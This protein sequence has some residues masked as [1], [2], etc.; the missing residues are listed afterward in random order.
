VGISAGDRARRAVSNWAARGP[1]QNRSFILQKLEKN[2][3]NPSPEADPATLIRRAY[4]DL[5]GLQPT[6]ETV[7]S[8]LHDPS[9]AAL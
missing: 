6:Y 9:P 2:G 5:V 7:Q 3:L 8:F 4:L 1:Q